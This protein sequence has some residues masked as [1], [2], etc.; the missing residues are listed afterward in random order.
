[1]QMRESM[2][3]Q[4]AV[5]GKAFVSFSGEKRKIEEKLNKGSDQTAHRY[6]KVAT[7]NF[8]GRPEDEG[9]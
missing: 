7:K 1:M 9:L 4:D 3:K 6:V 5:G 8:E 2:V